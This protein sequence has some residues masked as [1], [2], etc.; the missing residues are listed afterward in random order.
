MLHLRDFFE[1]KV[2]FEGEMLPSRQTHDPSVPCDG[3][4]VT[5]VDSDSFVRVLPG[6]GLRRPAHEHVMRRRLVPLRVQAPGVDTPAQ[7][8]T[9]R[10]LRDALVEREVVFAG[11]RARGEML[12]GSSEP[13]LR[14]VAPRAKLVHEAHERL[15]ELI[16]HEDHERGGITRLVAT[17]EHLV[18][19][20]AMITRSPRGVPIVRRAS[21]SPWT[22][23]IEGEV[24]KPQ[25]VDPG[26]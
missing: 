14:V 20:V 1:L 18:A 12:R 6:R 2:L 11:E 17:R 19:R 26:G 13:R 24:G 21:T 16:E 8:S 5:V 23:A 22:V 15:L 25:V 4:A 7:V 3:L 10:R 9:R